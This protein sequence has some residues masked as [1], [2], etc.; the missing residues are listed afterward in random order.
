MQA[1][2]QSSFQAWGISAKVW[3]AHGSDEILW[4]VSAVEESVTD[5]EVV[6]QLRVSV[7]ATVGTEEVVC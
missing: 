6:S 5:T 7:E 1:L 2:G 3:S 4:S